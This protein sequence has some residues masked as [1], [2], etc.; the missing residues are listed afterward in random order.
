MA[1]KALKGSHS[2]QTML[3][4]ECGNDMDSRKTTSEDAYHYDLCG[5]DNIF[6]VG[7]TVYECVGCGTVI[8]EI[9]RVPELHQVIA[10]ELAKKQA[11]LTG[12]EIRFLR[13]RA[14]LSAKE[15]AVLLD[16]SPEHL[17]RVENGH[18]RSLGGAADKLARVV[19]AEGEPV[20]EL[21]K[22]FAQ[23]RLKEAVQPSELRFKPK[24][25]WEKFREAA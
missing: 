23:T 11:F 3:C 24:K 22:R 12:R 15:F 5:L 8:P 14:G 17:S 21:L 10:E 20:Q 19:V 16:I 1:L 18:T 7:I 6:L 13:N 4:D 25:K 9:P 2:R